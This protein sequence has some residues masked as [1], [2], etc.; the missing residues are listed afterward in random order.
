MAQA[1][2][3]TKGKKVSKSTTTKKCLSSTVNVRCT[4]THSLSST[5]NVWIQIPQTITEVLT[6][7]QIY[8]LLYS[9]FNCVVLF[10]KNC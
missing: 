5:V 3:V 6:A 1:W 7:V 10:K 2:V 9:A 8:P 4:C